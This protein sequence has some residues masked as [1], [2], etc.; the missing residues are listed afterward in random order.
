MVAKDSHTVSSWTIWPTYCN[1]RSRT[2]RGIFWGQHIEIVICYDLYR[3]APTSSDLV[4]HPI[5]CVLRVKMVI[6]CRVSLNFANHLKASFLDLKKVPFQIAT[7]LEW[8]SFDWRIM[9][10][11]ARWV[12]TQL[13]LI[14]LKDR[15]FSCRSHELV[16]KNGPQ[17]SIYGALIFCLLDCWLKNQ[18]SKPSLKW[19]WI[20]FFSKSRTFQ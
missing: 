18:N 1:S 15:P 17:S 20:N 14:F 10:I 3:T 5:V 9:L 7:L 6:L 16:F 4:L 8:K 13:V 2:E 19:T 12:V 11:K